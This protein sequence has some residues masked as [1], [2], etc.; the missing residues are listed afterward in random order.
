MLSEL[1]YGALLTYSPRGTSEIS[2]QSQ[3]LCYRIKRDGL[4]GDPPER[5]IERA[6]KRLSDN[7][8][9]AVRELLAPGVTL[10]PCPPSAP[11]P[12]KQKSA[13]WVP[14]RICEALRNAGYGSG[15]LRC[16][17][18]VKAVPKSAFAPPG[19]RPWP[20]E[21]VRSMRV[22]ETLEQPERITIVDD[23]VTKLKF[24]SRITG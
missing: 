24:L 23:V 14:L 22:V 10:V 7:A 5:A 4:I 3:G 2:R 15:I 18:R 19:Q 21:H 20:L 13:L 6:I 8:S 11:F 17:E 12:P 1:R 9:S 16:L